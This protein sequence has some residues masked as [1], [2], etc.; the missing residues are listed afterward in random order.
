MLK[1]K[2]Q[3][4]AQ[5]LTIPLGLYNSKSQPGN[6]LLNIEYPINK[7]SQFGKKE[8]YKLLITVK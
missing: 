1:K 8:T 2:V 6:K 4:N 3:V 5:N 7:M